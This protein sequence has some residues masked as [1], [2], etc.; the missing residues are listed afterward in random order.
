MSRPFNW[1]PSRF[2]GMAWVPVG[3]ALAAWLTLRGRL[4]LAS[5]VISPYLLANYWLMLLLEARPL[6]RASQPDRPR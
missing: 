6:A 3:V 4:G 5:V 2:I 1:L